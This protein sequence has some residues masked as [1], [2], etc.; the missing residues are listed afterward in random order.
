MTVRLDGIDALIFDLDGVLTETAGLHFRAWKRLFEDDLGEPFTEEHYRRYVDGKS[1]LDGLESFLGSRGVARPRGSEDDTAGSDTSWG[2]GKLKDRYYHALLDTEGVA[3]FPDAEA[4]LRRASAVGLRIGMVS[5]S[6]NATDVLDAAGLAPFFDTS[7]DGRALQT[8]PLEGKP[9]PDL[10]LET[11]RRLDVE[12]DR[13][14]VFEDARSGVEAGRR[15]GFRYVVGVARD[16]DGGED[17]EDAGADIVVHRLDEV[18]FDRE[19]L[20]DA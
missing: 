14:A 9:A 4:L 20:E 17:L 8:V 18:T 1:R 5:S 10:F 13:A 11:A 19:S 12:P 6:R 2:L 16:P 15:G 7:V 3:P